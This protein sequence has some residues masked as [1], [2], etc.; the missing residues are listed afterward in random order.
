[1]CA[2]CWRCCPT[3]GQ[4]CTCMPASGLPI[5]LGS[6]HQQR[7]PLPVNCLLP[8]AASC[9]PCRLAALLAPYRSAAH[10][11]AL[12]EVQLDAGSQA[13]AVVSGRSTP[14][15]LGLE[16]PIREALQ[17]LAYAYQEVGGWRVMRLGGAHGAHGAQGG[18]STS[19]IQHAAMLRAPGPACMRSEGAGQ[20]MCHAD[21]FAPPPFHP[22]NLR[23]CKGVEAQ[24]AHMPC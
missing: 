23:L 22:P 6:P 13:R 8:P 10:A 15:M 18:G 16:V 24:Q 5:L 20:H 2:A 7:P 1:M 14:I 21:N 9:H 4:T 3:G 11:P 12:L 17:A 19:G